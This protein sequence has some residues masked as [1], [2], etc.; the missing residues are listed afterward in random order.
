VFL[1]LDHSNRNVESNKAQTTGNR[2]RQRT[3][4]LAF[5]CP[6]CLVPCSIPRSHTAK[7]ITARRG[8][9]VDKN[10]DLMIQSRF[11]TTT[12]RGHHDEDDTSGPPAGEEKIRTFGAEDERRHCAS[13]LPS[14]SGDDQVRGGGERGDG[15]HDTVTRNH[16]HKAIEALLEAVRAFIRAAS[17]WPGAGHA[18]ARLPE[19]LDV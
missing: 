2:E 4:A 11:P 7:S 10:G 14:A 16:K 8:Q 15:G 9:R 17:P 5:V 19:P 18:T 12:G 3:D 13:A 6:L 1:N